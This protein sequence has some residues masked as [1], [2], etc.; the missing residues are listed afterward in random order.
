[1][2]GRSGPCSCDGFAIPSAVQPAC[3]RIKR[4]KHKEDIYHIQHINS[5][6]SNLKRWMTRFN[7]VATKYLENYMK[8]FKWI[9]T[10]SSEKESIQIKS[11]MLHSHIPYNYTKIKEF[12]NRVPIFV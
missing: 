4:G 10:F 3:K 9:D 6:H 11:F 5:L 1:M 2:L 7:G 8:W 12:K